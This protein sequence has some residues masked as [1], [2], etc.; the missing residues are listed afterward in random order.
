MRKFLSI[1][2]CLFVLC[3]TVPA[4]TVNDVSGAFIGT[5]K[6]GGTPYPNKEIYILPGVESNTV[7]FVLPDFS[8]NGG[9][10]G[11]IVLVNIPMETSGQLTLENRPLYMRALDTYVAVSMTNG[12]VLSATNAKVNLNIEVEGIDPIAVAFSGTP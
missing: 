9:A 3:A 8:F 11:D 5:L 1:I 2:V 4:V 10:L 7:T 6:I 12:S